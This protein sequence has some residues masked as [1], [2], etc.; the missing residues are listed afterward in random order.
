MSAQASILPL[1]ACLLLADCGGGSDSQP[2]YKVGGVVSG[3]TGNGLV[4]QNNGGD[5]LSITGNGSFVFSTPLPADATY[6]VTVHTQPT[7]ATLNCIVMNA[8][9]MGVVKS[10]NVTEVS[11]ACTTVARL[12]YTGYVSS[13]PA[14]LA[15][16]TIL[17]AAG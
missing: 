14:L 16:R 5:D 17:G 3:L 13:Q 8:G 6:S 12:A 15:L 7:D 4:L 2:V 10:A 1:F 9:R 11:V